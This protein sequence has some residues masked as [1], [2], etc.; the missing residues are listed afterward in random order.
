M[1]TKTKIIG[2]VLAAGGLTAILAVVGV[3]SLWEYAGAKL[4]SPEIRKINDKGIADGIAFGKNTDQNGCLEKGFTL[5]EKNNSFD[6][7]NDYFLEKCLI[8]SRP[9]PNF[10]TGVPFVSG[11]RWEENECQK[12]GRDTAQCLAAMSAKR[13]YCRSDD[14]K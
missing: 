7:S 9:T 10:C 5:E 13:N 11:G 2:V 4:R 6:L 1:K 12:I 14:K 8:A 3:V